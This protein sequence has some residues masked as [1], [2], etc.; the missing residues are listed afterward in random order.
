MPINTNQT[1][2]IPRPFPAGK[3]LHVYTH[4]MTMGKEGDTFN[5]RV[6]NHTL[7]CGNGGN[8]MAMVDEGN[9]F[10]DRVTNHTTDAGRYKAATKI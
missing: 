5:D 3:G 7:K 8:G 6:R 2:R 10:E 1:K 4:G 9:T